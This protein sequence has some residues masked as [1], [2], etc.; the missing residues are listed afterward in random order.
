MI[1]LAASGVLLYQRLHHAPFHVTGVAITQQAHNGCG[2]DVTGRISTNGSAGTVSYQWLVQPS[3]QPPQPL[4][5]S[6]LAGQQAVYV[7]IAV[8]G[9]GQG[10]ASQTVTLQVLGPDTRAA[11]L[12]WLPVRGGQLPEYR[13]IT[14]GGGSYMPEW[15][16]PGYTE[17]KRIGSGGFGEVVLARHDASGTL[18]AIKYLRHDL[19]A[20]A[21]FAEMFRSEAA[22]LAS[23]DDPNIVRLYEY[24]ESPS[25]AAIVME[26]I[27]GVSLREILTYQGKTTA[28]GRPGRA[29]GLAARPGGGA[30]ARC[31]A[32]G[33]QARERARQRGRHQQADRLRHRG[34]RR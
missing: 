17:M 7:T 30:P 5:Q 16:V 21:E 33:L 34:A 29:A 13:K 20:D 10:S 9:A 6:V 12:R 19:L 11:S 8:E 23:L 14:E 15:K 2:V 25:G 24:V 27:G 28:G 31:R 3:Q 26:L 32:P 22:V 1:L 4:S 18:V